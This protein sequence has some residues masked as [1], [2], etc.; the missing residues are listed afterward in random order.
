MRFGKI[1]KNAKSRDGKPCYCAYLK[2]ARSR[3]VTLKAVRAHIWIVPRSP[4]L[5]HL[6]DGSA[7]P[8]GGGGGYSHNEGRASLMVEAGTTLILDCVLDSGPVQP[9]FILWFKDD[10]VVEYRSVWPF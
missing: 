8:G 6:E 9:Q 10:R 5:H 7:D 3:V 2:I 1:R 4:L